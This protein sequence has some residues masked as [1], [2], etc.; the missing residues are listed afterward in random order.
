MN[1]TKPNAKNVMAW[2]HCGNRNIHKII[3]IHYYLHQL[4]CILEWS[5]EFSVVLEIKINKE[6]RHKMRGGTNTSSIY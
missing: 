6:I 5:G 4:Y 2:R 1:V 3:R